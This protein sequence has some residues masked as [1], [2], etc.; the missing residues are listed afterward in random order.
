[1]K[2][3]LAT[4]LRS[5]SFPHWRFPSQRPRSVAFGRLYSTALFNP[6]IFLSYSSD[7]GRGAFYSTSGQPPAA[8]ALISLPAFLRPL[9]PYTLALLHSTLGR[10]PCRWY[11]TYQRS[12]PDT[13][14]WTDDV[15]V[16][17]CQ[18]I[19]AFSFTRVTFT[20]RLTLLQPLLWLLSPHTCAAG[21]SLHTGA[22]QSALGWCRLR[23]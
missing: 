2:T 5:M 20:S 19:V 23:Q 17:F 11:F 10:L 7:W 21:G 22:M 16:L 18:A 14:D 9:A 8:I 3:A 13:V 4:L 15:P 12:P 1:M 6:P